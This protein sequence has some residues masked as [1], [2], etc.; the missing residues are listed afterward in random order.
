LAWEPNLTFVPST[1]REPYS[2][3]VPS[4]VAILVSS[5][6]DDHSEDEKPP[7]PTHLP[8]DNSIE[9]EPTLVPSLPR[10]V[11]SNQEVTSDLVG[12]ISYQIITRS[13]FQQY[14]SLLAQ[15]LETHDPETFAKA[16]GY[17]DW[18]TP[19]NE[20]CHSLMENDTWDILPLLKGTKL[21]KCKWVYRT[22]YSSY[23]SV[24]IYKAWLVSKG[25]FQVEGIDYDE[26][27][28][29]TGK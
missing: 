29:P 6:S 27:F 16:S 17:P 12:D 19:M 5:S 7:F 15:V 14:F 3:F 25:F 2:V 22:K 21:F 20:E 28:S 9:H 18:D 11:H 23:G 8:L 10:W 13:Y 1:T 24:E 4:F 26:T